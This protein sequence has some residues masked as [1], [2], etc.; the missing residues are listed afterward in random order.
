MLSSTHHQLGTL[1]GGGGDAE[2]ANMPLC[3]AGAG[4]FRRIGGGARAGHDKVTQL[5]VGRSGIARYSYHYQ[6]AF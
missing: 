6:S 2:N 5:S 1:Q 3:S 4:S